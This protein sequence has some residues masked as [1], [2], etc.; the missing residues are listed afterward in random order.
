MRTS[1]LLCV[2][3][4]AREKSRRALKQCRVLEESKRALK[5]LCRLYSSWD[6]RTISC[7]WQKNRYK[8]CALFSLVYFLISS[9]F[10]CVWDN[11]EKIV[12][13]T[14]SSTAAQLS[15][16]AGSLSRRDFT[17]LPPRPIPLDQR[18]TLAGYLCICAVV[19]GTF[20]LILITCVWVADQL[21]L[22]YM[23]HLPW[24]RRL[25]GIRSKSARPARVSRAARAAQLLQVPTNAFQ[26]PDPDFP[27]N[28]FSNN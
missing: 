13:P 27:N 19:S 10:V 16:D 6:Y 3:V 11:P 14:F 24:L 9:A 25:A 23:K 17:S 22:L 2:L 20:G 1:A 15:E 21:E 5:R 4:F 28:R 18:P 26:K 8:L 7:L 12:I